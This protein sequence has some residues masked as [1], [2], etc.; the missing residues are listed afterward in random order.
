MTAGRRV[1]V[2]CALGLVG[3]FVL[4]FITTWQISIIA[5][6]DIAAA[7]ILVATWSTVGQLDATETRLHALRE[8]DSRAAAQVV[9]LGASVASL[10]AVVFDL[11]KA[12]QETGSTRVLHTAAGI[13][14]IALSWTVVHTVFSLRY[15]RLY[16]SPPVGGIDFKTEV[17]EPDYID[18]AYVSFTIGMTFQVSDT[19]IQQR[20]IRRTALRQALL[21]YLFG[22]VIIAVTINVIAT[23][24][25]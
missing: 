13:I 16:Y 4:G 22:A 18:F 2:A 23:L 1:L 11:A 3:G 5:G 14:T 21:S 10:S 24:F 17:D 8:D 15:A 9:L 12:N 7:V 25:Q 19:D 20:A 6:W